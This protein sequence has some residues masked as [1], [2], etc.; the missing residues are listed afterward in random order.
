MRSKRQALSEMLHVCSLC[1]QRWLAEQAMR[2]VLTELEAPGQSSALARASQV[3]DALCSVE[4]SVVLI[5]QAAPLR[6]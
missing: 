6:C 1:W 3:H 2:E 5:C 4:K